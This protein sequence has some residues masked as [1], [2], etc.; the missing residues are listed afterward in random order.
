MEFKE[1]QAIYLQIADYVCDHILSEKWPAGEKIISI[2]EL[3]VR[4]EVNPNTVMRTYDYLQQQGIIFNK[5]GIGYFAGEDAPA[6]IR[7]WRKQQFFDTELP[8]FV[9]TIRML[10]ISFEEVTKYY[11]QFNIKQL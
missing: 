7:E 2:R 6:T 10:D 4:L 11:E 3:A 5:R 9:R 1:K 8:A